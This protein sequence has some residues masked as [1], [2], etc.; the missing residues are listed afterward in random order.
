[1][2]RLQIPLAFLIVCILFCSARPVRAQ[3][4]RTPLSRPTLSPYFELFRGSDSGGPLGPYHSDF[5]PRRRVRR[6]IEEG[7]AGLR[8]TGRT[9]RSLDRRMSLAERPPEMVRPT[10]TSSV[11]MNYS[12]Y[13]QLRG[14]SGSSGA[15]RSWSPP[16]ARGRGGYGGYG[17]YGS[18]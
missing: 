11:F 17:S 15:R 18:F 16:P 5:R 4:P 1:M 7:R 10:G 12:H 9:I 13:Y 14:S 3:R 6:A 8:H 2:N